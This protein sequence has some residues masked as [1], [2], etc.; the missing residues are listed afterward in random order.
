MLSKSWVNM[1]IDSRT[2]GFGF[3]LDAQDS[4]EGSWVSGLKFKCSGFG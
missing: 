1:S 4:V 3:S 2:L